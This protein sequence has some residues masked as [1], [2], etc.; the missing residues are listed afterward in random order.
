MQQFVNR[1]SKI[2]PLLGL[3]LF[4]P[5]WACDPT[6]ALSIS[7]PVFLLVAL[8]D[9]IY[10]SKPLWLRLLDLVAL[11]CL[12][13][14]LA[15]PLQILLYFWVIYQVVALL[16]EFL[17]RRE[18]SL[19]E[20]YQNHRRRVWVAGAL[21]LGGLLAKLIFY[22]KMGLAH[23]WLVYRTNFS[24]FKA[25]LLLSLGAMILVLLGAWLRRWAKNPRG[26]R[27]Q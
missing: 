15:T 1:W 24:F 23:F 2:V 4:A 3:G 9:W 27:E 21:L 19:R 22:S 17:T 16:T 11:P 12:I 10:R 26:G 6:A 8:V 14:L 13:A 18:T 5:L 7:L 20:F 25:Y